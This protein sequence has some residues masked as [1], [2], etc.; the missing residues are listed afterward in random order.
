MATYVKELMIETYI[1]LNRTQMKNF[2]I[3]QFWN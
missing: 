2:V 1:L 3:L